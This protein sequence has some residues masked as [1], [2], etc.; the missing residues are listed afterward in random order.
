MNKASLYIN[1]EAFDELTPEARYWIGYLA[2]DGCL[3][4][5]KRKRKSGKIAL[6][7]MVSVTCCVRNKHHLESFRRFLKS[8]HKITVYTYETSFGITT[9][10]KFA[11]I[12]SRIWAALERCG[13]TPRK[14]VSLKVAED[15]ELDADFWRGMLDGDGSIGIQNYGKRTYASV[16]L[17]GSLHVLTQFQRYVEIVTGN[18]YKVSAHPSIKG[19]GRLKLNSKPACKLLSVLY[20]NDN[21]ALKRNIALNAIKLGGSIGNQDKSQINGSAPSGV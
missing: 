20:G 14:S 1:H 3:T 8:G 17:D 12:S 4:Y 13:L 15:L 5:A 11:F 9:Q 2:A 16:Q 10:A 7:P 21:V 18:V 19:F 6:Y